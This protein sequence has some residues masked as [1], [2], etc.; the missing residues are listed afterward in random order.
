MTLFV[1]GAGAT[2]GC[3]FVD[4]AKEPC[5]P[6]LD[7]DFFGQLQK[8]R[9][10]KHQK[11]I[12]E[13]T[14]HV[15]DLFGSNF[16]ATLETVFT[17]LEHTIRMLDVT[18]DNRAF[19]RSELQ[20]RRDRLLQAI[21]AVM[22]ESLTQTIDEKGS[23]RKPK[24]CESHKGLVSNILKAKDD[25]ISFNY[26]CVIDYA[27]K[28]F[29]SN[30]WN[31]RYGYGFDL[32]PRGRNLEGDSYWDPPQ[33][34]ARDDT[35]HLYKL[36]G[37]L[38]FQVKGT[39]KDKIKLKQRPYTTQ[40]GSLRFDII[41][42]EWNKEYDRGVFANLWNRA[43][44]AIKQAESIVMIGYSLPNTDLHSTALFRTCILPRKLKALVVVNPDKEARRR[45]RTVLQR[46]LTKNTRVL[47]LEKFEEFIALDQKIW[48]K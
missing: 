45:I 28:E 25:I 12:N 27:L 46:G 3:S 35:V 23:S 33:Q 38:H 20:I 36:H 24:S 47:S 29:G 17:T 39:R 13:V 26:D 32:G 11:L 15:V 4:A 37:S 30:K 18:G 43:A 5:L 10:S 40:R 31:A 34:A 14:S 16:S 42:P 19:N 9:N 7:T 8:I 22:E 6:P 48:R 41:P 2:R 21:A 44:L 1:L